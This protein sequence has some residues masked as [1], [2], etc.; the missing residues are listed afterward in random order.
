AGDYDQILKAHGVCP[1]S[2]SACRGMQPRQQLL[3]GMVT[4]LTQKV[5]P[6]SHLDQSGN[7]SPGRHRHFDQRNR[8]PKEFYGRPFQAETVILG[9]LFP[10]LQPHRKIQGLVTARSEEHTSELQSRVDLVCRLLLEQK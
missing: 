10:A 6:G 1:M 5:D 4:L 9:V 3:R 7:I 8:N 2:I